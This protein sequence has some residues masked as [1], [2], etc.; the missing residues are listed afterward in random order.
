MDK[1]YFLEILLTDQQLEGIEDLSPFFKNIYNRL[2]IE[3]P[4]DEK[5][6]LLVGVKS[7]N[8]QGEDRVVELDQDDLFRMSENELRKVLFKTGG[9]NNNI[10]IIHICQ[11]RLLDSEIS[12]TEYL[13]AFEGDEQ[14]KRLASYALS[15]ALL[16]TN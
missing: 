7:T 1:V 15:E 13:T 3:I 9:T 2:R 10:A 11:N 5:V 8:L 12:I 16:R 6:V 14:Q 4:Q